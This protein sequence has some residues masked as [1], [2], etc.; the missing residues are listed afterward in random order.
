MPDDLEASPAA[1]STRQFGDYELIEQLGRGGMGV[2][3]KARQLRLNRLVA[4]KMINAG[5]FASPMLVQRF[6]REAEAAANLNH[7]NIVPIYET[8]EL[9]GQHFFSMQLVEG[10]G[11][12]RN[13]GESGFHRS[14]G[15]TDARSSLRARQEDIA[16]IVA[17]VARAVDYA[18]QHGVLHRDLKPSNILLDA[19]GEPH[20]TDFGVAKVLG[21]DAS[22]LTASGAIMGT[23]S[24]MAPEQAAGDSKRITTAGDIYS[25]GAVLYT[26]L[27]GSPPFRAETPVETLRQVVEQEP[28]HPSTLR[29]GIDSDLATIAMKCLEKESGRRYATAAFLADD[30]ER[31]IKGEPILARPV[32]TSERFWRWCRRNPKAAILTGSLSLI[33]AAI[34]IGSTLIALHISKLNKQLNS[35]NSQLQTVNQELHTF[36]D[37]L[38]NDVFSNLQKL[39]LDHNTKS[40]G[41][42][43]WHRHSLRGKPEEFG[44]EGA[45]LELTLV[46]YVYT[47]PRKV[48]DIFAPILQ[49]LEEDVSKELR[50][51]L[52][53]HLHILKS[54]DVGYDEIVTNGMAF[55][56]VG[57]SS[58]IH[59][60]NQ[61]TGV[62]QLAMQDHKNALIMGLIARIDSPVAQMSKVETNAALKRLLAGRSVAL[63]NSNSTTGGF[64][65]RAF[66]V[67]NDVFAPDLAHFQHLESHGQVID[68][69][70][71]GKFDVGFVNVELIHG[72]SKLVVIRTRPVSE[73][74]GRC[75]IAGPHMDDQVFMALQ[76]SLLRMR[77]PA[78]IGKIEVAIAGFKLEPDSAFD[79]LRVIMR[80]ASAFD[81]RT[82]SP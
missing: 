2:I 30:L 26:M 58:L 55:G 75:F 41:I 64:V 77:D 66:L 31:W 28:R 13:I 59:L 3:Y 35:S 37:G 9:R 50:R 69:V 18:H 29:E 24:Y 76:N 62:R 67:E 56:R 78:I 48:L 20:L 60:I 68:A 53:I 82:N 39:Y 8:G 16:R 79:P 72:D 12:D 74:L 33:L 49:K 1:D 80:A 14:G 61:N 23:P 73:D 4:I 38:Q 81:S 34:S 43:A 6:H 45:Q 71:S 63:G 52:R 21:H 57:P 5:E 42:S 22:N 10:S 32:L 40:F 70:R 44:L 7:P 19:A 36:N 54:Y 27:T 47:D 25:L 51:P 65:A 46:D 15:Q 17:K 11:L